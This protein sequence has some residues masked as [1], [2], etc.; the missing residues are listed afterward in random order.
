MVQFIRGSAS[1]RQQAWSKLAE[2]LGMSIGDKVGSYFVNKAIDETLDNDKLKDAPL[3]EKWRAMESA[4]SKYGKKGQEVLANRLKIE[5]QQ[6]LEK[7]TEKE[8]KEAEQAAKT[9]HEQATEL[10]NI[11]AGHKT[12]QENIKAENRLKVAE[13]K[14][15]GKKTQAS[16]PI[17]PEQLKIIQDVRN[18]PAYEEASPA[19][20]Y[21]MMTDAG[22]SKENS[23]AEANIHAEDLKLRQNALD[24]SFD[25]QKDFISKTTSQ[26]KG[27]ETD[28]KPRLLQMQNIPSEQLISPTSSVFLETLGIPLGALENPSSE[29][30]QK[31][32]QDLLKGLPE[33]YGNRILK[34]EVDNFLKTIPTLLNSA[35]GRRM[36]ASNMLKL[37]EMKEVYY[38]EMRRQEKE[39]IN[40]NKPLPRDFEQNVFD[41]AKPELDRINKDFI[42]LSQITSVPKDTVPYFAPGGDIVFVPKGQEQWAQQNGGRKIW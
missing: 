28:M 30:Y 15:A 40:N 17:D 5:Q 24:K 42:Q 18:N 32:S 38:N 2:T 21:Q 31:L 20:K 25:A 27:W 10:E 34:V 41:Q 29:L 7:Q 35:D 4:V 6:A 39:S 13:T 9:K 3:S 14:G 11:K 26:Y 16:Q 37:G 33:T 19:K 1:P 23:V 36:I 22:V 12:T 8:A